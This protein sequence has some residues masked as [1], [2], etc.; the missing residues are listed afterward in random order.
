MK[1]LS[2]LAAGLV[3]ACAQAQ[4][5]AL[6]ARSEFTITGGEAQGIDFDAAGTRMLTHG[7]HGDVLL[8]D[9][10]TLAVIGG[11]SFPGED[12][13]SVALH[14]TEL[15]A[16]IGICPP[17]AAGPTRQEARVVD[18]RTGR[19]LAQH[20]FEGSLA[21][22]PD[23]APYASR[24]GRWRGAA[25]DTGGLRGLPPPRLAP[26]RRR[27]IA[28]APGGGSIVIA[29]DAGRIHVCQPGGVRVFEKHLGHAEA[30]VFTPDGR[31]LAAASLGAVTFATSEGEV[32][33]RVPAIAT[34][35]TGLEGS[36]LWV[37]ATGEASRFDAADARVLERRTLAP[38]HRVDLAPR[39]DAFAYGLGPRTQPSQ[40]RG[41]ALVGGLE[42]AAAAGRE[43]S[44]PARWSADGFGVTPTTEP[45]GGHGWRQDFV[46][47]RD[48]T[49]WAALWWSDDA[50]R[51]GLPMPEPVGAVG[52][53]TAAGRQT[54]DLA[55]GGVPMAA[56]FSPDGTV[57]ALSVRPTWNYQSGTAEGDP[58]LE[59][60]DA[61]SGE[62]GRRATR[63]QPVVWLGYADADTLLALR[64]RHLEV[65]DAKTLAT[66]ETIDLGGEVDAVDLARDGSR[67]ALA[68]GPR[69]TVYSVVR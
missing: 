9:L 30:L 34:L 31:H 15:L 66:R 23:L 36:E 7:W 40:A 50:A 56:A 51:S 26:A 12:V 61:R 42:V 22:V 33:D 65:L 4:P 69:V 38:P 39:A 32:V 8:W 24:L 18:L 59:V 43:G 48:G 47:E 20:E 64:H 35:A 3:V 45:E 58:F 1:T 27:W 53:F 49:R 29:D 52:V 25:Q 54:L 67:L 28:H 62:I 63:A 68:R 21:G 55:V 16:A 5:V 17:R 2:I 13:A 19:V 6:V 57:L 14:P 37:I 41:L 60:R 44:R 46:R 11:V 10:K